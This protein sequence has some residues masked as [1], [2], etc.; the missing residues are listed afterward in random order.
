MQFIGHL[1]GGVETG[2]SL[3]LTERVQFA[4]KWIFEPSLKYYRQHDNHD[5]KL[6]RTSPG[7]KLS[8]RL[9]ERIQLESEV[10]FEKSRTVGPTINDET[11]RRFYFLGYRWDF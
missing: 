3:G 10:T 7:F 2:L 4:E 8:Y 6:T 9:Q 1:V 11:T 5:V